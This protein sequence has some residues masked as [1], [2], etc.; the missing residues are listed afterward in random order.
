MPSEPP[1]PPPATKSGAVGELSDEVVLSEQAASA[2][3]ASSE[4]RTGGRMVAPVDCLP[5]RT[6]SGRVT[7]RRGLHQREANLPPAGR[8]R[9]RAND[10]DTTSDRRRRTGSSSEQTRPPAYPVR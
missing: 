4:A 3:A 10:V 5:A 2:K 9:R 6:E 1:P 7:R 8:P